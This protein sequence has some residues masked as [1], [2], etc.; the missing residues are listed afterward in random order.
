MIQ[1]KEAVGGMA[2]RSCLTQRFPQEI[3]TELG[4]NSTW[5][6]V[7]SKEHQSLILALFLTWL[8][9]PGPAM[10]QNVVYSFITGRY[11][12]SQMSVQNPVISCGYQAQP[13]TYHRPS[14]NPEKMGESI[15]DPRDLDCNLASGY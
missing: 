3:H 14:I 10:Y 12:V 4:P 8:C 6:E 13:L 11:I 7:Q 5:K 9:D 1:S 15:E 2:P